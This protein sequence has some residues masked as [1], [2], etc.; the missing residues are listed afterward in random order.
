MADNIGTLIQ[1]QNWQR[2]FALCGIVAPILFTLLVIVAS[3]IRPEYSQTHNFVSDLG[4]GP[5]AII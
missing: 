3:L 5:Y 2:I 4:V 1:T